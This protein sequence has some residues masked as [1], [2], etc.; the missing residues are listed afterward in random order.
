MRPQR[1]IRITQRSDGCMEGKHFLKII[2][3]LITSLL[4][5]V[6]LLTLFAVITMKASG[7][8]A[9]LF[10]YQVKTVL[11][12]SMEPEFKTG[13]IITINETGKQHN[14][15][16]GDVI[17]FKTKD[18]ILIT[19]RI[20]KVKKGGQQFITKGDANDAPDMEP[21]PRD[22][23]IG[24]Y[25]GFTI[26]YLGYIINFANSSEGAA[27][28]LVLPGIGLILYSIITISRALRKVDHNNDA[29]T[30]SK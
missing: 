1:N 16:K 25:T 19:H 3:Q 13:S 9:S 28:L 11:S 29:Q 8:Q 2:N 4:F 21:V 27:L 6:L 14:Y 22:N 24:V 7:G 15:E 5:I 12:G 30:D 17:T 20:V 23:I 10:G 26:P 18:N